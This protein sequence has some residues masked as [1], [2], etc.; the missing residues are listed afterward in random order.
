MNFNRKNLKNTHLFGPSPSASF[1]L[2]LTKWLPTGEASEILTWYKVFSKIGSQSLTSSTS[3][4]TMTSLWPPFR[5]SV[6]V[7][8]SKKLNFLKWNFTTISR[9]SKIPA[10]YFHDAFLNI[11]FVRDHSSITSAKRWL[12]GVRKWQFLLIYSR[13]MLK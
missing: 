5:V 2:T 1:E 10:K 12:V 3:K 11:S 7:D 4:S 6:K 13:F 9:N 8:Y